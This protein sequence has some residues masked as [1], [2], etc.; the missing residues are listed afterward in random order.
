MAGLRFLVP[1]MLVRIQ[2]GQQ[3]NPQH[4]AGGF[5]LKATPETPKVTNSMKRIRRMAE[6]RV[7]RPLRIR[8]V[9][10]RLLRVNRNKTQGLQVRSNDP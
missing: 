5:A 9:S 6:V 10:L 7:K 8:W 1:T 2:L 4:C 3:K